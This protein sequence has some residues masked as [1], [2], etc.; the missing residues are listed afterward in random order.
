MVKIE[1]YKLLEKHVIFNAKKVSEISQKSRAYSRLLIS[2]MLKRGQIYKIE[3]N[4]YTVYYDPILIASHI[5]WP[6]YVSCWA[7]L[8]YYNLTEQLPTVIHVITPRKRLRKEIVFANTKIIFIKIKPRLFFG[9][10]KILYDPRK[11]FEIFVADREKTIID[12]ALLKKVSFSTLAEII[13][14]K[15]DEIDCKKLIKYLLKI[16]NITLIKRF[17]FILERFGVKTN[18]L[19]R[20]VTG[21]FV[22]LDYAMPAKGKKNKKWRVVV[23]VKL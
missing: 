23:N 14:E 4:K 20:F 9:Y 12:S 7:G 8:R 19:Q 15:I 16:R 17:G 22:L 2:R 5:V 10:N 1:T 11:G 13:R 6:S 3:R 21:R 18:K